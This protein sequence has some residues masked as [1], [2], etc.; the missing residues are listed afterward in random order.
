MSSKQDNTFAIK[1]KGHGGYIIASLHKD[2]RKRGDGI[3][4]ALKN[5]E[6]LNDRAEGA[7][8]SSHEPICDGDIVE[9]E[10]TRYKARVLGSFNDC[11]VF[12]AIQ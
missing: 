6:H 7:H 5:S 2:Y 8:P 9:I 3:F 12:D 4:W 1:P 10:G 11:A